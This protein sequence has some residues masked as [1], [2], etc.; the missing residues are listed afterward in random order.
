VCASSTRRPSRDA[1]G[2]PRVVADLPRACVCRE[3]TR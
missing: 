3:R 1:A 2:A